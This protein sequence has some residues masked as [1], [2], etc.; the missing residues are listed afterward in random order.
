MT[1]FLVGVHGHRPRAP[2]ISVRSPS[3]RVVNWPPCRAAFFPA[4][5][6]P[7]ETVCPQAAP[8]QQWAIPFFFFFVHRPNPPTLSTICLRSVYVVRTVIPF[9]FF[10]NPLFRLCP[11]C[12]FSL[13][14]LYLPS[15][16]RGSFFKTRSQT[17]PPPFFFAPSFPFT[18]YSFLF[19]H[20]I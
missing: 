1:S 16:P 7:E 6:V 2:H 11:S 9:C 20:S 18:C 17:A 10:W 15:S 12:C 14:T 8:L 5:R 13:D 3:A 19:S 4:R